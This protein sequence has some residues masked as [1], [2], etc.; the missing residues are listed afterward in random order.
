MKYFLLFSAAVFLLS[1]ISAFDKKLRIRRFTIKSRKLSDIPIKI[2]VISD[3]HMR[4]DRQILT[5]VK[6]EK[7]DIIALCGDVLDERQSTDK[8][9]EKIIGFL[10]ELKDCAPIYSV[11]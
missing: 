10:R 7:P 11:C 6:S 5:A 3:M 9:Y 2:M 1:A 8:K 4:A